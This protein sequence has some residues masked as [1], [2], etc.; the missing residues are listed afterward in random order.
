MKRVL[1]QSFICLLLETNELIKQ[2]VQDMFE[3]Y[4]L[5]LYFIFANV[6]R[7]KITDHGV[8]GVNDSCIIL[9]RDKLMSF[10]RFYLII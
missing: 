10:L 6:I 9:K 5:Y 3:N 8:F 1:F 7:M 2:K 4:S